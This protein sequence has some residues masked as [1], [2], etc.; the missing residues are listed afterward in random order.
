MKTKDI[1][2]NL[3]SAQLDVYGDELMLLCEDFTIIADE[4]DFN[5]VIE[6][7]KGDYYTAPSFSLN[8][9]AVN[10]KF[11]FEDENCDEIEVNLNEKSFVLVKAYFEDL[12][13][14][15]IYTTGQYEGA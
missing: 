9:Y 1:L 8:A 12:Y 10:P 4:D 11:K 3:K 15:Y 14:D 5:V 13:S 2:R 6:D 7:D